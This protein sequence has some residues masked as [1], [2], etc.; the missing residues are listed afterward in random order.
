MVKF[1]V[2]KGF[3]FY[4]VIGNFAKELVRGLLEESGYRVYPY[5]YESFLSD[6]KYELHRKK[7]ARTDSVK[8]L[9][10]HPDLVV[11]DDRINEV[12]FV[13]VKFRNISSLESIGLNAK[14]ILW[15]QKYWNDSV[16][17]V[18]VPIGEVFYAQDVN[19]LP[20]ADVS[21]S[22]TFVN[23]D[24][25]THFIPIEKRFLINPEALQN[26]YIELAKQIPTIQLKGK[27]NEL[28]FFE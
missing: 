15:Y 19:K 5:G 22:D 18:V 16:L 1:K 13:E 6:I 25:S 20:T 9:R 11:Y 17:V 21:E 27:E 14:S 12:T 26:Y 23:F 7:L 10:S 28:I 8:R 2:M 3:P 24:L 4:R